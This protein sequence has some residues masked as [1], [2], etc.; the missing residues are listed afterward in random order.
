MSGPLTLSA[1][2]MMAQ[3]SCGTQGQM[4][5]RAV[6]KARSLTASD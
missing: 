6:E 4:S 2:T 1:S 3:A 5:H